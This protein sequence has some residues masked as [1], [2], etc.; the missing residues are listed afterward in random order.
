[1]GLRPEDFES[2]HDFL[3]AI[4]EK[5]ITEGEVIVIRNEGPRGGPGMPEMLAATMSISAHGYS[6]VALITDGRFSGATSGPCVG[7]VSPEACSGGPIGILRDGDKI[8]INIPER[9]LHVDLSDEEI[10][11]R[12]KTFA[13]VQREIPNGFMKRYVRM[14][15]SAAR[16]AILE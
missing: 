8:A 3:A 13:P 9:T 4:R 1:M 11:S 12:F 7:H 10:R 2:E 5:K 6:R 14:V 15:S 16:G